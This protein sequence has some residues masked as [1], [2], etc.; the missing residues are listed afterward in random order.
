M[1]GRREPVQQPKLSAGYGNIGQQAVLCEPLRFRKA[2]KFS[3]KGAKVT[4]LTPVGADS[5]L[6]FETGLKIEPKL[7]SAAT[8]R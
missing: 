7:S 8:T 3:Q 6:P 4:D 2:A 1:P 5:P